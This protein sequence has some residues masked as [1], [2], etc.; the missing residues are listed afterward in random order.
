MCLLGPLFALKEYEGVGSE[1]VDDLA[2]ST[3]GRTGDSVIIRNRNR[4]DLEIGSGL[5]YCGENCR[6]LGAISHPI[7]SVFYVASAEDFAF[8]REDGSAD[9][10]IRIGSVGIAHCFLCGTNQFLERGRA[11]LFFGP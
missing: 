9:M 5:C 4:H 1:L 11:Y 10:K 8:S 6:S 7:R 3:T 2:A